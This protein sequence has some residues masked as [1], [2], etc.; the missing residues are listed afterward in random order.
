VIPQRYSVQAIVT[1]SDGTVKVVP[2]P[3]D[4]SNSGN[5]DIVVGNS[6]V[7][8]VIAAMT[9][10]TTEIAPYGLEIAPASP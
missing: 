1:G 9:R 7:T 4:E 3:L 8:L 10:H 5:L 2:L 6:P